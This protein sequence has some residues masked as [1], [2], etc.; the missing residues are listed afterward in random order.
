MAALAYTCTSAKPMLDVELLALST[1][2]TME[3]PVAAPPLSAIELP[4]PSFER[5]PK[6]VVTPPKRMLSE[7][8]WS[9]RLGRSNSTTRDAVMGED[10]VRVSL[11]PAV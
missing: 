9:L 4:E 2:M 10:Q 5:A 1:V 3:L 6:E 8:T 7:V 11:A